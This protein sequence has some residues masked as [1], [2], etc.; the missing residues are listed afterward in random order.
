MVL[1]SLLSDKTLV[2][3]TCLLSCIIQY[4]RPIPTIEPGMKEATTVFTRTTSFGLV[5]CLTLTL[6]LF[7]S[8][9]IF[10]VARSKSFY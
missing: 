9:K 7:A 10:D 2:C 8:L 3:T 4:F 5:V 1:K 6:F